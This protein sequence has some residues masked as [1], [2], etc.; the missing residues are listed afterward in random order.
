MNLLGRINSL[1]KRLRFA[2][3]IW[4][5]IALLTMVLPASAVERVGLLA[6]PSFW[7][8]LLPLLALLPVQRQLLSPRLAPAR[9]LHTLPAP[10]L[11]HRG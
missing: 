1:P 9:L 2:I 7:A 4:V 8:V 10:P 5:G 6:H 11:T 3:L